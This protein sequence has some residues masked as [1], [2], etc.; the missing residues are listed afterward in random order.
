MLLSMLFAAVAPSTTEISALR[1]VFCVYF[2]YVQV[3]V[4]SYSLIYHYSLLII[5][6]AELLL[7]LRLLRTS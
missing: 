5:L 4:Y 2:I 7:L 6:L 3:Y 1:G